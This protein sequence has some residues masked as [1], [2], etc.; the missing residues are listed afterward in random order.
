MDC[1]VGVG[2][3]W[4]EEVMESSYA[5]GKEGGVLSIFLAT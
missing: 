3:E 2:L 4:E 5:P 1:R